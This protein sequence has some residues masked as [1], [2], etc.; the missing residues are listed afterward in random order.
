MDGNGAGGAIFA[1]VTDVDSGKGSLLVIE[2]CDFVQNA[3]KMGSEQTRG[4]EVLPRS[5]AN[6]LSY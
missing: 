5:Q 2:N 4:Y 1:G 6:A 3:D